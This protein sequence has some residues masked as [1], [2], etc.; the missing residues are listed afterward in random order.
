MKYILYLFLVFFSNLSFIQAQVSFGLPQKFN[1]QWKFKLDDNAQYLYPD[2]DDH[3]W[4][5]V[6]LPHDWSIEAPLSPSLASC[7]GYLPGGIGWYIKSIHVPDSLKEKKIFIYFEGIYNKSEVYINGNLL[8][9]RPN[10]Y[11][12]FMYDLTPYI[13]YNKENSLS[14]RVD[15]HEYADS[16]W[17]TGSGI[18]R[19]V[20]LIISEK[21]HI[22]QWGVFW[23]APEISSKKAVVNVQVKVKNESR[24]KQNLTVRTEL[25][26]A[27]G[28]VV[29]QKSKKIFIPDTDSIGT[30]DLSVNVIN[31]NLWN[32][33]NPYLYRLKTSLQR[34]GKIIDESYTTVGL[35]KIMFDSKKGFALNDEWIKIKGVCIHHD[36]GCLGAAVPRKVWKRRLLNL[37]E[38]GCNAIRMSH[39]PH[40]PDL[41][42]LCDELGFLVMDEAFDEWKYP[43]KKS[44]TGWNTGIPGYE[45]SFSFFEEWSDQDIRDMVLRNRNHPSVIMWSIGNEIDFPNDPYSHPIL[46]TATFNQPSVLGYL[47]NNPPAQ[48]L[49]S[50]A[51]RLVNNVKELDSSRPVTA[52]LAGAVM[53]N[54]TDYPFVLDIVGYNYSEFQ[55]QIDHE[56]FPERIMFGS[57]TN[58]SFANWKAVRDNSYIFG[59]FIWTGIDYLGESRE[60]PSRGYKHGLLDLAGFQKPE[61]FF[62]QAMWDDK[63]FIYIGTYLPNQ[64]PDRSLNALPIWNY[65]LGETVRVVCYTNCQQALLLLNGHEIGQIKRYNDNS[66]YIS[67]D[68]PFNPG[69]LEVVGLHEGKEVSRHVIQTS[70]RPH[71]IIAKVEESILSKEKDMTHVVIQIVD[72]NGIPVLLSDNEITCIIK[73]PLKLLGL[74]SGDNSDM[75]DYRDNKQR[76]YNGRL[77]AY[78]QTIGEEG[79][80]KISF[81][82]PWLQT[83]EIDLDITK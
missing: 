18:Y 60:W 16:R 74:E 8:G 23:H 17:Y 39:N 75:G 43:K 57:E 51:R 34:D 41:Y 67:W 13:Q 42:D 33:Q 69:N 54:E 4:R 30:I 56:K 31:P 59:Q 70:D 66:G 27:E 72:Q 24:L 62:R 5:V 7:T 78:I 46:E 21:V 55:Y 50:I 80:A 20:W 82:S 63:P 19:N 79:K 15:H 49:G 73:G 32:I 2:F 14:V 25:L 71:K 40:A 26:S 22:D 52:A 6:D 47:P 81:S 64:K 12:S 35:R 45:G 29:A 38:L 68:I 44:I 1:D 3:Q 37:K 10:G 36:A 11:V 83:A 53:S 65:Q 28:E 9:K 76:V 48:E 61:G 77:V 58:N